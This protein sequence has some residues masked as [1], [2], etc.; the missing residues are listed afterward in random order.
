MIKEIENAKDKA[1]TRCVKDFNPK[2]INCI[3]KS[4]SLNSLKRCER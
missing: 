1:I 4:R 3:M 2:R